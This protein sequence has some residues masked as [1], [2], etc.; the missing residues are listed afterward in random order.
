MDIENFINYK[1]N[2]KDLISNKAKDYH[3]IQS[4]YTNA[5]YDAIYSFN[6]IKNYLNKDYKILEIGGGIHLLTNYLKNIM[7]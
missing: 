4:N 2:L 6:R 3:E 7:I 1:F 5:K